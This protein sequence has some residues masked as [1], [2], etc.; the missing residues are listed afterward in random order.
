MNRLSALVSIT[1]LFLPSLVFAA[2]YNDGD[3]C[4]GV[5]QPQAGAFQRKNSSDG[6]HFLVC[7]GATW[8]TTQKLDFTLD[9]VSLGN[10]ALDSITTGTWNV[11]IG[12]DALGSSVLGDSNIAIGYEALKN[13]AGTT[14]ENVA[15]GHSSMVNLGISAGN[16]GNVALGYRAAR[17]MS[18]T[19]F[20]T[21]IGSHTGGNSSSQTLNTTIVGYSSGSSLS[22]GDNNLFLG[23]NVGD[24]TTTGSNN[25]LIGYEVITSSATASD[26]LNI[27]NSI[28]GDLSNNYIGIANSSPDAELDVIG[29]IEFTGTIT[30]VS[31]RRM[32]TSIRP[33]KSALDGIRKLNGVSFVMKDDPTNTVELGLIAQDVQTAF[34]QLVKER[35]EGVL[36]LNYQGM[37]GPLVEA[38]KELDQE[39]RDLKALVHKMDNRLR[40]LEGAQRPPLKGY[41]N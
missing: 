37:V 20:G 25:I 41:N 24:T 3:A 35:G 5:G 12:T 34:P 4:G 36:S 11:A 29:N 17:S 23:Y 28:Y 22:G 26:E 19:N 39:N 7:D 27:G 14:R 33:I 2:E 15:I 1:L 38:V 21:F 13:A 30:D 32:K 31:D 8:N 6:Y 16:V 10:N 18:N 9:N 40:V